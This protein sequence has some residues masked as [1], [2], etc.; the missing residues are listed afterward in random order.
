MTK[1]VQ[2]RRGTT[3]EHSS[4]TG[5][6]GEVT[7]DITKDT[8][9]VHD[10]STSGG[11]PLAKESDLTTK[12][13]KSGDTMTG[14]LSFGDNDKAQFGAGSDLQIYHDGGDSYVT[15][16]GGGQLRLAG[17]AHV[18]ILNSASTEFKAR[19]IT[20]GAVELYHD[21]AKKFETTS[22]GIDVTGTVTFDGGTTSANLNFGDDD[23]AV[24]GASSDFTIHHDPTAAVNKIVGNF[25]PIHFL[26]GTEKLMVLDDDADVQLYYNNA[27]KLATT[28]YGVDI[29]GS[30]VADSEVKNASGNYTPDLSTYQ[31]FIWTLTGNVVF[32]NPTTEKVGQSGFFVFIQDAT[33]GRTLSLN[34]EWDTV[35]GAGITLSTTANAVDVVPYVVRASGSV[36]L[37][38]P[39]LA[40]S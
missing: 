15:D 25:H 32:L 21:N 9:V 3:A 35:G 38:T 18:E 13:S 24:F 20:N 40:F 11:H 27:L 22:T 4:F 28:S 26:H 30:V 39:Q 2:L 29:S 6:V 16:A 23:K 37:G 17:D 19:F 8:A 34:S 5:V 10:G 33:G 14:D 1:Q 36:L 7:V 31:N 12:V